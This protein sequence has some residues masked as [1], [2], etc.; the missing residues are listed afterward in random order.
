MKSKFF[1]Q[2]IVRYTGLLLITLCLLV[3]VTSVMAEE[4][5][6]VNRGAKA[7]ANTCSRCHNMRNASEF[8]DDLW[9]PIVN[10][11]RIRAGI[12]GSMARDILAYLQSSNYAAPASRTSVAVTGLSGQAVYSGTCVVCHGADGKGALPG[13]PKLSDRLSQ[14]SDD[15]LLHRIKNGFQSSGSTMAMPA[16]GGNP[17]LTDDDVKKVLSFIKSNFGQ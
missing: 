1:T 16:R 7:W 6:D 4:A 12:P 14:S 2:L 17:G 8:R 5:G 11:M 10:H 9:Q 13:V 3:P 15:V